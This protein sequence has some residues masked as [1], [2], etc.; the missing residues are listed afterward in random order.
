MNILITGATGFIGQHL[1][2]ELAGDD[3]KIRIIS[4]QQH[5]KFWCSAKG[6]SI[7]RADIS[8]RESLK[9]VFQNID[10][11]INLA[12][13]LTNTEKFQLT[14]T[15]GVRN[16]VECAEENG[17]RKII[18]LSS[19]GVVGMQY[20]LRHTLVEESTP[21]NP[22]NE[23]ERTK[24][25]AERLVSNSKVPWVIIRPTNVFGDHHPRRA[26]L[27]FFQRFKSN[28]SFS[29]KKNAF[30]NYVYVKDVAHAIRFALLHDTANKVVNVGE[31]IL[32]EEFIELTAQRLNVAQKIKNL[33]TPFVSAM[34]AIGYFGNGKLKASLRGISNCVEYKD[35]SF[36]KHIGYKYGLKT[37]VSNSV[38]YYINQGVLR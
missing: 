22:K 36:K 21:C 38:E 14:N 7:L 1:L 24:L 8:N 10:V 26:L 25:E 17:V 2:E 23:Y 12:A 13:E 6:F 29:I 18:H 27:R 34:E 30:V 19:V 33:P 37:G 9:T 3:L 15:L 31:A 11:V 20:S 5:P 4:R 32:L 28:K 16:I 35:D